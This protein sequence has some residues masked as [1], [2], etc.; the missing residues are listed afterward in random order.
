MESAGQKSV[1]AYLSSASGPL[2]QQQ[3][4]SSARELTACTECHY[5]EYTA[6]PATFAFGALE[7]N[8]E[9]C[10]E[11]Y[12]C[13]E[14]GPERLSTVSET[15]LRHQ[16]TCALCLKALPASGATFVQPSEL[17]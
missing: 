5:T 10:S 12:V 7:R 8:M 11:E 6:G 14:S 13:R 3:K 15:T 2:K 1:L 9:M 16:D 4:D 17:V